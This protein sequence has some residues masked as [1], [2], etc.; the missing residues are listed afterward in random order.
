MVL[1]L[2]YLVLGVAWLV[3]AAVPGGDTWD[4]VFGVG[5]LVGAAA[6]FVS[7]LI[8]RKRRASEAGG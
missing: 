8:R 4:L 7:A 2:A 6:Y 1:A 5:W 3:Q